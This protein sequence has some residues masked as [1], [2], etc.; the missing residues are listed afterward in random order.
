MAR[1]IVRLQDVADAAGVSIATASRA[2]TGKNRVSKGT[3]AHV[4]RTAE[5]MGYQVNT[6]G[7]AL[8]EGTARSVGLVVPVIGNPFFGQLVQSIEDELQNHDL[9]LII[10]DSHGLVERESRRLQLLVGR[11]VEGLIVV[12]SDAEH[13]AQALEAA[14]A[15]T[16]LVQLDRRVEGIK[17]DFIGV[18]NDLAMDLIID[19]LVEQGVRSVALVASDATTSAGRERRSAFERATARL[20]LETQEHIL[21][22]FTLEF[23]KQAAQVLL[24][25]PALPDAVVAGD[26]LIAIGLVTAFKRADVIVPRDILVTGFDGTILS[27]IADPP[28]TTVVQPFAE[29]AR[30]ATRALVRRSTERDAPTIYSRIAPELIV[31]Q[32]TQ[33]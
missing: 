23:G 11:R 20:G 13:S 1:E 6:I 8:R 28:L 5:R 22:E 15:T 32:S 9:E 2:L 14:S 29:L 24:D 7:R 4:K 30:E 33:R 16:P 10:A 27:E 21:D 25:R 3:I 19:H 12:P 31:R 26:D 17:T 18:D